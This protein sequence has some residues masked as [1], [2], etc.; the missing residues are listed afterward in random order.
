[1]AP[2]P[3]V[4]LHPVVLLVVLTITFVLF[5]QV[6]PVGVL[7]VVVPAMVIAVVPIVDS[8]LDPGLLSFRFSHKHSRCN[9]GGSQEK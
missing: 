1:M 9:N 5:R 3:V 2:I 7:F 4:P 8:D 6:T